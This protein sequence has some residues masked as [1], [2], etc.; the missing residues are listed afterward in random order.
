[1]HCNKHGHKSSVK[2]DYCS[3][4]SPKHDKSSI[5]DD[6]SFRCSHKFK[7]PCSNQSNIIIPPCPPVPPQ[8]IITSGIISLT[9]SNGPFSGGNSIIINGY[10]LIQTSSVTMNSTVVPFTILSN[11]QIIINALPSLAQTTNTVNITVSFN[12]GSSDSLLYTYLS[13]SSI[14][15]LTPSSG[16]ITGSNIITITGTGLSST[17]SIYF[18]TV[19]TY[20]FVVTSDSSIQVAVPNLTG[21]SDILVH[22]VTSVGSSNSLPY[23]LVPPPII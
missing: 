18:N 19:P 6:Y 7:K 23:A 9:P 21:Q 16:P 5:K 3:T 2:D 8:I 10:N 4:C 15:S 17:S 11:N 14:T 22:V 1:M 12:N 20:N 13:P